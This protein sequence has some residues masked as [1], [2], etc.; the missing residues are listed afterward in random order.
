M[1]K[2]KMVLGSL[3]VIILVGGFVALLNW[4]FLRFDTV[5]ITGETAE[6][7]EDIQAYV[8]EKISGRYLWLIPKDSVFFLRKKILTQ[9]IKLTFP[10]LETVQ[11]SLPELNTLKVLLEDK[12]ARLVWCDGE[13]GKKSGHCYY[14]NEIGEAYSESP[15]FSEAVM[16][17]IIAPLPESPVGKNVIGS[18]TVEKIQLLA[19]TADRLFEELPGKHSPRFVFWQP[20]SA[21]DWVGQV[22][23]QD[24]RVWQVLFNEKSAVSDL[25]GALGSIL[26]NKTFLT[27]WSKHKGH[28]EYIDLR[29]V[30]KIFYRFIQ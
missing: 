18:S 20:L 26:K 9:A 17:E 29:F 6:N 2:L 4:G 27:D 1:R 21:G 22:E 3:L 11:I 30:Q 28:L 7:K 19:T 10:R 23:D 5:I 25:V 12:E 16:V 13:N 24:G 15:N 14:I 8:L